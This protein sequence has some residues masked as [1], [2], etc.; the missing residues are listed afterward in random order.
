MSM[1]LAQV[2]RR[3][4]L[5]SEPLRL[6]ILALLEAEE[7]T[8]TDLVRILNCGQ[9]SVSGHLGRLAEDGLLR[10]RREGRF[11]HYRACLPDPGDA[12]A[13]LLQELLARTQESE[14]AA[15]DR[16]ALAEVLAERPTAPPPGTLG[17][18]YLPGRTWEGFSKALLAMLPPVR[19]ADLGIGRGEIT[20]LLA[21]HASRVV[22]VD[23]DPVLLEDARRRAQAA[24]LTDDRLSFRVGD[25]ADPPVEPGE[26]DVFLMSQVLH[27]LDDPAAPL[28]AARR[29]LGPGGRVV[30]LDLLA[31]RETW[32]LERLGHRRLGFSEAGLR[33]LLEGAGFT[34]VDVRRVG[35]DKKP[36]HFVSLLGSGR[37][38]P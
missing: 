24:G 37:V 10:D 16:A 18:D 8:V 23:R 35:R 26:V 5:L 13:I 19:I 27:E 33:A 9:P 3:L 2:T 15:N 20:L 21:E 22:A 14:E 25:V 38:S 6:R 30:V 32:V 17:R 11:T 31:H 36:P 1:P 12:D 29:L 7:L 4:R 34:E 28:A